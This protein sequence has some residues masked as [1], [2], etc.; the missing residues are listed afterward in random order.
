MARTRDNVRE[1]QLILLRNNCYLS[2]KWPSG[3][4]TEVHASR[5]GLVRVVTVKTATNTLRRHV[6]SISVLS[7]EEPKADGP[8]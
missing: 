1:R 4:I 3:C 5:D 2:A 7:L 6:T 8:T